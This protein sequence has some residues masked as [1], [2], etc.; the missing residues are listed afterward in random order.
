MRLFRSVLLLMLFASAVPTAVLGWLLASTS[1]AQLAT[2][3]L[4]LAGERVE[5]L[6]LQAAGQLADVR[7]AVEEAAREAPWS[8][9]GAAERRSELAGLLQRRDEVTVVTLYDRAGR[10]ISGMQAFPISVAPSEIAEHEL[11]TAPLLAAGL[12]AK[13]GGP[14][15]SP[16]YAAP[17]RGETAMTLVVPLGDPAVGALAAEISLATLQRLVARTRVGARGAAFVVDASGRYVAHPDVARVLTRAHA[18]EGSIVAEVARALA[19][20]AEMQGAR[21]AEFRGGGSEDLLGAYAVLPEV[22]WGAV[23]AQPKADAFAAVERMRRTALAGGML[24]LVVAVILGAWFA[25]GIARPVS[26]L[27]KGALEIARGHFGREIEVK[28]RNEIGDLAYTFNHMS[29]ELK[30]YDGENRRL[31]A[32]L[33]AGYLDTIRSLAGAIDA[34]DAYTRGHNQRVAEL[35]VEIGQELRVDDKTLRALAYGGLL[36]DVGKIGIPEPVLR[37]QVPLDETEMMLMREHPVIGAEIVRGVEFLRDAIPAIRS[38]HERWDGTG[39]PD[40]LRAE[41]IP[42]VARIVNA[43]DTWD[44]C[45]SS[46]PYQP[47]MGVE[48]VVGILAR[49]RGT[50]IDPTVHDAL[51]A[52]LNRWTGG[53]MAERSA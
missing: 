32:A 14:R 7:R 13:G 46:R 27:V 21:V 51:I 29:R 39:Y 25:R 20:P 49:L 11:A 45:T 4:E 30:S 18:G 3:A 5:R 52:V 47:A 8:A 12:P 35:A 41:A 43:A 34:K 22:G 38:H 40:G 44:A 19:A 10:K 28:V 15:W 23:A 9:L 16:V 36:H 42:L 37:K 50:Q 17:R 24:S 48:E 33:E 26:E 6:R 1:R 31:I 2:D 53:A